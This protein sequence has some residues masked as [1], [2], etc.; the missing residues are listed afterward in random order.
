[1]TLTACVCFPA[2]ASWRSA[3]AAQSNRAAPL[4][5]HHVASSLL[6]S[7]LILASQVLLLMHWSVLAYTACVKILKKHT[8]RTGLL[9]RAPQL[10]NLLSQPFC[11]TEVSTSDSGG[12]FSCP[13]LK[14]SFDGNQEHRLRHW[15]AAAAAAAACFRTVYVCCASQHA[16]PNVAWQTTQFC[17]A[18]CYA[19]KCF[20]ASNLRFIR[21]FAGSAMDSWVV[22]GVA[23]GCVA[24][25][26]HPRA[27]LCR[28]P[29]EHG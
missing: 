25:V 21:C 24:L 1:M 29:S 10:A 18:V 5:V 27:A 23:C 9:V 3:G 16:L 11:S 14:S 4:R 20:A 22:F 8:K 15:R 19:P 17:C 28:W 13:D 12:G 7:A 6:T 26:V 2:F